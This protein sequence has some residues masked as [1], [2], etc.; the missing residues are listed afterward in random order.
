MT[1]LKIKKGDTVKV[2]V[3]KDKGKTGAVLKAFPKENKLLVDGVNQVKKHTKPSKI[4][5]GGIIS[6]PMPIHVSNVMYFDKNNSKASRIGYKVLEDGSK[7]RFLKSSGEM[8]E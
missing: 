6:K 8:V 1:K 2:L 5:Q 3:G 7:K 4:S